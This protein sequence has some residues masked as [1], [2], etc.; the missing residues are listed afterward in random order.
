M[1]YRIKDRKF[2]FWIHHDKLK[3]YED[4]KFHVWLQ[5]QQNELMNETNENDEFDLAILF[6]EGD[7]AMSASDPLMCHTGSDQ[8][9]VNA[10]DF[11]LSQTDNGQGSTSVL[12]RLVSQGVVDG[13][14]VPD[15]FNIVNENVIDDLSELH[16]NTV[17]LNDTLLHRIHDDNTEE[18][19][20]SL[21]HSRGQRRVRRRPAYLGNFVE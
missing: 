8:D 7:A 6:E 11:L 5:R 14:D 2:E 12:D 3:L 19:G 20:R 1:L 18:T 4:I 17:N 21:P 16:C 13:N 10:S 15:E 9:N